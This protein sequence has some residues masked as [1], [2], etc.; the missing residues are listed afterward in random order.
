M[1]DQGAH[2]YAYFGEAAGEPGKGWYSYDLGDW[3][4]VS[5]NSNCNDVACGPN[6]EQVQWLEQDLKNNSKQCTLAYWHHPRFSSGKAGGSGTVNP[7]WRTVVENGVDVVVNGHDH[8]YERFAPLNLEGE[9]VE[10]GT[11][12]FIVGTGGAVLR[13]TGQILPSSEVRYI[14]TYGVI[15]F[16]LYP[17]H[18]EWQFVPVGDQAQTDMG[19]GTCH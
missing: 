14:Q 16:K 11:R 1:T 10:V 7:F 15:Q 6:S 12:Q 17:G 19:S 13:G 18:Y 3:H 9:A 2:Y 4:I 5:L 8:N